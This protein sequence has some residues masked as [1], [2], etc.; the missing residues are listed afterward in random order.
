M[1]FQGRRSNRELEQ[2]ERE[3]ERAA[4][5]QRRA[6]SLRSLGQQ[7]SKSGGKT[8]RHSDNT[9]IPS[10]IISI[11]A[12][13]EEHE[14]ATPRGCFGK[15]AIQG[16]N[17]R[18]CRGCVQRGCT[19]CRGYVGRGCGNC[20]VVTVGAVVV[21]YN[22]AVRTAGAMLGEAVVIVGAVVV[23]ERIGPIGRP[24]GAPSGER[25]SGKG[26]PLA[27]RGCLGRSLEAVLTVGVYGMGV[28]GMGGYG[29]VGRWVRRP[30]LSV[31]LEAVLTV[32][33]YGMGGYGMV[34]RWV[35]R[36]IPSDG[37]QA[38]RTCSTR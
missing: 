12:E 24:R 1:M 20:R 37:P 5:R 21:M 10:S 7:H 3:Q 9:Q 13:E 26:L 22:E 31:L 15:L 29:M 17:C 34:G 35:R 28:Y 38:S 36:P 14:K 19:N 16:G 2:L 11:F 33:V 4:R 30:I 23:G 25:F 6:E 18:G 8:K 32:G 27:L